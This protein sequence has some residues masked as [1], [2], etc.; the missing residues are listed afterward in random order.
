MI[1]KVL[2]SSNVITGGV[3]ITGTASGGDIV[4]EEI[5]METDGTGLAAGT[6]FTIE[7]DGGSGLL[8]FFSSVVSGLGANKTLTLS[9][10][11][12]TPTTNLNRGVYGTI[13]ES[14]QKL[15]AKCTST[16]CT[17]TGTITLYIRARRVVDG[18]DLSAA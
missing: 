11:S 2:I 8:T 7:K 13:L 15:V 4:I 12:V 1:K 6:N 5:F 14:G 18:A 9:L 17:G 3:D 16:N 10:G